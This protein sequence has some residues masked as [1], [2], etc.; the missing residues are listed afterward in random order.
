MNKFDPNTRMEHIDRLIRGKASGLKI[1]S[2]NVGIT[3]MITSGPRMKELSKKVM[4]SCI[5][6][7]LKTFEMCGRKSVRLRNGNFMYLRKTLHKMNHV[8]I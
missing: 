2:R 6:D 4:W 3:L 5:L 7:L 8:F 1:G